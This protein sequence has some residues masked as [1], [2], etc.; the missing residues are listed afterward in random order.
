MAFRPS[1]SMP[2]VSASGSENVDQ[3]WPTT[4]RLVW[5]NA[6]RSLDRPAG[7]GEVAFDEQAHRP[8][9]T[10]HPQLGV[11]AARDGRVDR[12]RLVSR[13]RD[14][15]G[16]RGGDEPI[17]R[18]EGAQRVNR[19]HSRLAAEFEGR[20]GPG[21]ADRTREISCRNDHRGQIRRG[22]GSRTAGRLLWRSLCPD[23]GCR[24]RV[25]G[26]R[27]PRSPVRF[28]PSTCCCNAASFRPCSSMI[29]AWRSR[30]AR[31]SAISCRSSAI[32]AS[33]LRCRLRECRTGQ[34]GRAPRQQAFQ[35][36]HDS[37]ASRSLPAANY[38]IATP[39]CYGSS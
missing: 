22:L 8:S 1:K 29:R 19:D 25:A 33:V 3:V 24:C 4:K 31:W 18:P 34:A 26:I 10:R 36:E 9:L 12:A 13:S 38:I 23:R 14:A 21:N 6:C 11:Q 17:L 39:N 32:A 37:I 15:H 30:A 5:R 27:L 28:V 35:A 2:T 16:N 20:L 7:A